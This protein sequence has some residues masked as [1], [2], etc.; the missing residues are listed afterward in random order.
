MIQPG[1]MIIH[2]DISFIPTYLLSEFASKSYVVFTG[3]GG[4]EFVVDILNILNF[5]NP[6]T[7]KIISIKYH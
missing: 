1:L 3:D 2:G 7:I 5:L 6:K 4:D